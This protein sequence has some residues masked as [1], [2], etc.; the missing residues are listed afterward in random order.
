[1]L[2]YPPVM[3]TCSLKVSYPNGTSAILPTKTASWSVDAWTM[4]W[5]WTM[6][7]HIAGTVVASITCPKPGPTW[8]AQV[9]INVPAP[10]TPKPS[11]ALTWT[12]DP[13]YVGSTANVHIT[14]IALADCSVTYTWPAGRGTGQVNLL[15]DR[16]GQGLAT[17]SI[18]A[19]MATG[20]LTF[21]LYCTLNTTVEETNGSFPIT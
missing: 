21:N 9:T 2:L 15:I 5:T 7:T 20:T 4:K 17:W 1:M 16:Y 12:A 13:A 8:V 19:D 10:P 11:F 14:T 6:P 18:P 3:A